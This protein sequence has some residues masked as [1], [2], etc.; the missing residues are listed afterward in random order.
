MNPLA[1]EGYAKAAVAILLLL[2]LAI[3]T[4][5]IIAQTPAASNEPCSMAVL[6]PNLRAATAFESESTAQ[7]VAAST[8]ASYTNGY[9]VY[10]NSLA[11]EF[12]WTTSCSVIVQN[13]N[14]VYDLVSKAANYTLQISLNPSLTAV[15]GV[16]ES[17]AQVASGTICYTSGSNTGCSQ[18]NSG[19]WVGPEYHNSTGLQAANGDWD[20]PSMQGSGGSTCT[21]T[22]YEWTGLAANAGGGSRSSPGLAQA[23]TSSGCDNSTCTSS[24]YV[25]QIWYDF[26]TAS[27]E[28]IVVCQNDPFLSGGASIGTDIYPGTGNYYYYADAYDFTNS[29]G[30]DGTS[31]DDYMGT[32]HYA[33]FMGEQNTLGGPL[34]DFG[35]VSFT[36]SEYT[37]L[38]SNNYYASNNWTF[39]YIIDDTSSYSYCG[40]S[41]N[42]NVCPSGVGTDGAFTLTW[43]TSSG[44]S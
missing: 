25:Y 2:V 3:P 34:P 26:P 7:Q 13:V 33:E 23:G 10:F 44:T 32:A 24:H 6:Q 19:G 28:D 39:G 31:P 17:P 11:N 16:T 29:E 42:Y 38:Y 5:R 9:N 21:C 15:T 1:K 18:G 22:F 37:D 4:Q 27:S 35:T 12:T 14:V 41:E 40:S 20:V 30:C 8:L 36:L 43:A